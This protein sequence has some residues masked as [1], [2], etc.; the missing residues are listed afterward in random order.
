MGCGIYWDQVHRVERDLLSMKK[1]GVSEI[2]P[3]Y[4][5]AKALRGKLLAM[6]GRKFP[7]GPL[8]VGVIFGSPEVKFRL[9]LDSVSGW[10]VEA[11][12]EPTAPP[13]YHWVSEEV[14]RMVK[15]DELTPEVETMLLTPVE[16]LGE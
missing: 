8:N 13:I 1:W 6:I 14:A 2:D 7:R 10:I 12:A 15:M 3:G 11:R 16:Y 5:K 9:W 4:I